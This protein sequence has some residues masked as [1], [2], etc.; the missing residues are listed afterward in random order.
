MIAGHCALRLSSMTCQTLNVH[1][2]LSLNG[3]LLTWW[4][5]ER[6]MNQSRKKK[7][8]HTLIQAAFEEKK[9]TS[10][11]AQSFR[12]LKTCC[13]FVSAHLTY[14]RWKQERIL[15]SKVPGR[16]FISVPPDGVNDTSLVLSLTPEWH[17]NEITN[18]PWMNVI[19]H[20]VREFY[21]TWTDKI[22]FTWLL[23]FTV[24]CNYYYVS[25]LVVLLLLLLL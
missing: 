2:N 18:T 25:L 14:C 8:F 11:F 23:S 12:H 15:V 9:N 24:K 4:S 21:H 5:I 20:T 3:S 10:R 7:S 19:W 17:L 16:F 13:A 6:S 22:S 1:I